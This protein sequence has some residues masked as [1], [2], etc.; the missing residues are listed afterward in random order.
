M[1]TVLGAMLSDVGLVRTNNEDSGLFSLPSPLERTDGK[2]APFAVVADGMGG[3]NAGEVASAL[4]VE[5]IR[6]ILEAGDQD[7]LL[8]MQIALFAANRAIYDHAQANEAFAGMG[9]TCT[10]ILFPPEGALIAHVG[11]S[12]AYRL[13]QGRLTRLTEDQTLTADLVRKGEMTEEE[14]SA[15]DYS[16]VLMQALG[17]RPDIQPDIWKDP[18]SLQPGDIYMLCSDGLTGMVSD[19]AIAAH[20]A[21]ASPLMA[22]KNLIAA[23]N[24]GGGGDNVSV[25]VFHIR[26]D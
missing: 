9:T 15:S 14:A 18:E 12:R 1:P 26:K 19:E 10:L 20:L 16:N 21:S 4:A 11:D 13:R 6:Q 25:G 2:R 22:C 17:T 23:A 7:L 5:I 8:A 3:H 24:A